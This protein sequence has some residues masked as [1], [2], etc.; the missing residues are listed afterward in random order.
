M[1]QPGGTG[2]TMMT[3][4]TR[5]RRRMASA[6]AKVH[7]M[8]VLAPAA[9]DAATLPR[10][11]LDSPPSPLP[12][13]LPP[14]SGRRPTGAHVRRRRAARQAGGHCLGGRGGVAGD[15]GRHQWRA[16]PGGRPRQRPGPRAGLLQPG[17][18]G[19][20]WVC[21]GGGGALGEG[22]D[23]RGG[24]TGGPAGGGAAVGRRPHH[25]RPLG[26]AWQQWRWGNGH[27]NCM[28][29]RPL[30][31]ATTRGPASCPTPRPWPRLWRQ[32]SGSRQQGRPGTGH[33]TTTPRWCGAALRGREGAGGRREGT[34][35]APAKGLVRAA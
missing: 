5:R 35:A 19:C 29:R 31:P 17:V 25:D 28:L 33:P 7:T 14:S 8:M 2:A 1:C 6:G 11:A 4:M 34:A 20:V 30:T 13:P 23:T 3:T 9:A 21:G 12:P 27:P 16:H 26:R 10:S 24:G 15:A 22:P 18:C 32:S